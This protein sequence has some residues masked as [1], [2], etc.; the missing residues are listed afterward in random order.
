MNDTRR[1]HD[2]LGEVEV[3]EAAYWGAQTVRAVA[4]FPISG[5]PLSHYPALLRALAMVKQAAARANLALGKLAPEKAHAIAAAADE[6]IAGKFHDQFP[7]DVIQGGA[8]TST[9][10]NMNEVLANRALEHLG[11]R[12]G[13]YHA[14]HPNDDVNL[15]Q[16]T[17][18]TYPTAVR[19]SVL[20]SC[21]ALT[22]ALADLAAAFERKATETAEIVKLGRTQLQDAVPMT[23]GQELG[24]FA[25]AIRE[26]IQRLGEAER[27]LCEVNLGGTAI[28]TRINADPAYGPRAIAE[29]AAI[30]GFPLVQ[31]GNLV[32]AS[33]DMGAFV[34]FSGVLKRV[35]TKLSKIANDLRLLSSG[36]RGGLAEIALPAVQPGSSIMPGKV[37]PVIP[38]VVNQ[39]CFQ[40]IGNDLAITLAAEGGQLQLNA[41]EPLI[42]HNIHA[43]LMLLTNAVTVLRIR[44]VEGL[45][46]RPADCARHLEASVGAVTALVPVIG[47]EAAAGLAHEALASGRTIRALAREK[48]SL[49]DATLNDLLNP[50]RLAAGRTA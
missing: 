16:S 44:C 35:A 18:D 4:N 39:V 30:S 32:E 23:L 11:H 40:V 46:P 42:A 7:V 8:G 38:E 17:N 50:A 48:F 13:A 41:F 12:R 9:N 19:L 31:S 20:L 36:P 34:M 29:L 24:A 43:S 33:W 27:L 49:D 10:M 47:Y 21:A 37:N 14:L 6:I 28:G 5:V 3:P 1:E 45:A 15:S 26:D 22:D 2:S 25:T